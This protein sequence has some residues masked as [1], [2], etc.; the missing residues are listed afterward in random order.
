MTNAHNTI[1]LIA[2]VQSQ[3]ATAED[4]RAWEKAAKL[5]SNEQLL[6][7]IK[8]C[9]RAADDHSVTNPIKQEFYLDQ[10]LTFVHEYN[11]RTVAEL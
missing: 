5:L 7:T 2:I 11:K 1:D 10:A 4:F 3:P 8:E 9:L 6:H